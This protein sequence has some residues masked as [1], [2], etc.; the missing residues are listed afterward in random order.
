MIFLASNP[1]QSCNRLLSGLQ[2]Q[3]G[4]ATR[5]TPP[6]NNSPPR[7]IKGACHFSA[8]IKVL[9]CISYHSQRL[10]GRSSI[11][12]DLTR[13]PHCLD[14]AH[15]AALGSFD[16]LGTYLASLESRPEASRWSKPYLERKPLICRPEQRPELVLMALLRVEQRQH[17]QVHAPDQLLVPWPFHPRVAQTVVVDD[18]AGPR[19]QRG[20]EVL[21]QLDRAWRRI[22]VDD[23]AKEV[24]Y[25]G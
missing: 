2:V 13:L 14:N 1:C 7:V 3:S 11:V 10:V 25:A 15:T 16:A 19:L 18:H 6:A 24:D 12:L 8:K 21:Q 9:H 4:F 20:D 17:N 23:P 22:V 5:R